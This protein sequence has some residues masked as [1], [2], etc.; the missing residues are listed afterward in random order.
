MEITNTSMSSRRL[1]SVRFGSIFELE[2][3]YY[4]LTNEDSAKENHQVCFDTKGKRQLFE[5]ETLVML[6]GELTVINDVK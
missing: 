1:A 4:F 5:S 3:K 6:P 2:G